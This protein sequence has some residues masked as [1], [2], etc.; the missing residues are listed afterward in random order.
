[1][2]NLSILKAGILAHF[3]STIIS[4]VAYAWIGDFYHMSANILIALAWSWLYEKKV[5]NIS[6]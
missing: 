2:P 3:S 1:M 6:I 5:K 4:G